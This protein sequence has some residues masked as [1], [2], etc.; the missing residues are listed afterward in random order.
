M[1]GPNFV[2]IHGLITPHTHNPRAPKANVA[3]LRRALG[4]QSPL[5]SP[6]LRLFLL[7]PLAIRACFFMPAP[8]APLWAFA[9]VALHG[10]LDHHRVVLPPGPWPLDHQRVVTGP[11]TPGPLI[12]P[13]SQAEADMSAYPPS[14]PRLPP[15]VILYEDEVCGG[16]LAVVG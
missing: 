2:V 12:D 6:P 3:R 7:W 1:R 8:E 9:L 14:R 4:R 16:I 5:L 10:L 15:W 13:C 11:L